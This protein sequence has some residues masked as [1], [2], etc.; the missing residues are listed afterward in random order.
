[1]I[2]FLLYL[3]FE[4]LLS[5]EIASIIG[6][7]NTFLEIIVSALLGIFLIKNFGATIMFNLTEFMGGGM[8]LNSFKNRNLFPFVGAILIILPGFLGDIV[9]LLLQLDFIT[10]MISE[11]QDEKKKYNQSFKDSSLDNISNIS[12]RK[13]D[14]ND[15]IDINS[16]K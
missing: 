2:Y 9:G 5:V 1:M 12:I 6:G 11:N 7:L 16:L 15:F 4:V 13:E 14:S 3:L 8:S 10:D